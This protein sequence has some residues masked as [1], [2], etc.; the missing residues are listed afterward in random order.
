VLRGRASITAL[1][2]LA[3]ALAACGDLAATPTAGV[4]PTASRAPA[5]DASKIKA[6]VTDG[7]AGRYSD[8][9]AHVKGAVVVAPF[10]LDF[11]HFDRPTGRPL[12]TQD[13]VLRAYQTDPATRTEGGGHVQVAFAAY[14]RFAPK[15]PAKPAWIVVRYDV[16]G[17]G[18][19][20]STPVRTDRVAVID[21]RTLRSLAIIESLPSR[22]R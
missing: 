22:C 21:D 10:W 12:H 13:Q 19:L 1:L 14:S 11:D 2:L 18:S 17:M 8:C 7:Y 5:A 20:S 4:R 3:P 16:S 15:V 6:G 9:R